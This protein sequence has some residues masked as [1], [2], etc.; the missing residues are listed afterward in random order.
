MG[1]VVTLEGLVPSA[2]YDSVPW[3]LADIYEAVSVDGTFNLI[4]TKALS[5]TDADPSRPRVRNITTSNAATQ[6]GFYKVG[7]RDASGGT[8]LTS[9]ISIEDSLVTSDEYKT[10]MGVDPTDTRN[11]ARI[12]AL[13][14]AATQT[15][16]NFTGRDF[17]V[18][19][20]DLSDRTYTYD[21][22]GYLEIDDATSI[23]HLVTNGG[24]S[25]GAY[26]LDDAEWEQLPGN[27]P[28]YYYIAIFGGRWLPMSP[29][30]GFERNLDQI[31]YSARQPTLTVTA[32][33]GW[34]EVPADV[35]LATSMV[36]ENIIKGPDS[37]G[38]TA[39]AIEG[40]SR[41]WGN[42]NNAVASLA[43]PNRARDIL[44]NY[45]RV[46]A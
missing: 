7:F 26:D 43:I 15:V 40:Y 9:I 24:I 41:S 5:P 33:W 29:E 19:T 45:Q 22:S 25:G 44:V 2:R 8:Q 20:G 28:I 37:D 10:L 39:E 1:F 16:K 17:S 11:D 32:S 23:T 46:Y 4:D 6:A 34:P 30:M 38:L 31:G 27:S 21:G 12:S 13:L 14:T 3:T 35:K 36:I 42:S 18:S